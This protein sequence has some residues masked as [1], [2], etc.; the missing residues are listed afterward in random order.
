[1]KINNFEMKTP[2]EN[3]IT[4]YY[5]KKNIY[6]LEK[7]NSISLY[8]ENT[9]NEFLLFK[10]YNILYIIEFIEK[11]LDIVP[12][13]YIYYH[14]HKSSSPYIHLPN[15]LMYVCYYIFPYKYNENVLKL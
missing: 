5:N 6:V 8:N 13:S 7:L 15:K 2:T 14:I 10:D 4:I 12:H 11:E 3:K 9:K 1:M